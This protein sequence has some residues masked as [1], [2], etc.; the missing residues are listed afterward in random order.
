MLKKNFSTQAICGATVKVLLASFC[1]HRT[2]FVCVL[3]NNI[4]LP[5]PLKKKYLFDKQDLVVFI[6][7][8]REKSVSV[9]DF[10]LGVLSSRN[11]IEFRGGRARL[12]TKREKLQSY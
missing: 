12:M 3:P 7:K 11:N 1:I 2:I 8:Q 4:T 6:R 5:S 9:I 10:H